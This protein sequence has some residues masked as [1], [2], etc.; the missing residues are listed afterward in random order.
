MNLGSIA[1]VPDNIHLNPIYPTFSDAP[2]ACDLFST[3]TNRTDPY[4][5]ESNPLTPTTLGITS[6]SY[7]KSL[8]EPSG[9][10]GATANFPYCHRAPAISPE[11]SI[12]RRRF[13]WRRSALKDRCLS[14]RVHISSYIPQ[15]DRC[16][17]TE[18]LRKD[19]CRSCDHANSTKV[20]KSCRSLLI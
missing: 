1:S 8:Y 9:G 7:S 2:I 20:H 5:S 19:I 6:S 14:C 16:N 11:I 10:Y 3:T 17:G 12:H 18:P 4:T 13:P 15:E